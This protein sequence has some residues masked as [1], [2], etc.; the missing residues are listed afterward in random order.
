[1]F[2]TACSITRYSLGSD[3]FYERRMINSTSVST[4]GSCHSNSFALL[5]GGRCEISLRQILVSRQD[6]RLDLRQPV[7]RVLAEAQMILDDLLRG[8]AQPLRDGNV[9]VNRRL[10]HFEVDEIGIAGVFEVVRSL[11]QERTISK[12]TSPD[13]NNERG[14]DAP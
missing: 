2:D 12:R 5:F 3:L 8:Q 7:Q 1:M 6:V 4:L 10:Q 11:A 9:V 13:S 14:S